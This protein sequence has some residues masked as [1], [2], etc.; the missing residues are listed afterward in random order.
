MT[1]EDDGRAQT[2]EAN[3]EPETPV[4]PQPTKIALRLTYQSDSVSD[5]EALKMACRGPNFLMDETNIV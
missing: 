1:T 3:I 5:L 4:Q 2:L